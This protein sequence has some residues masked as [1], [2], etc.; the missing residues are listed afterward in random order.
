[1]SKKRFVVAAMAL[2]GT[3]VA[4]VAQAR[5]SSDV[6]W[7]VTIGTPVG[8]PVYTQPVPVYTRHVPV[9]TRHVP[10]YVQPAPVAHY[11]RIQPH[12]QYRQQTRW[13]RD[14]DGIPNRRDWLYNPRWD[15]DGDGIPNR[16]DRIDNTRHDRD[17][18]GIPNRYDRRDGGYGRGR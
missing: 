11:P 9:Y 13:D 15:R 7:S 6:Q 17:G 3:L 16:R 14:G 5:S 10:V 12:P 2:A 4:G 8:V 1:M 18:D